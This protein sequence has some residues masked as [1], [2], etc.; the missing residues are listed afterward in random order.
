[1]YSVAGSYHDNQTLKPTA[2]SNGYNVVIN[3]VVNITV[4]KVRT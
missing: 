2:P 3:D 4:Q 1:M